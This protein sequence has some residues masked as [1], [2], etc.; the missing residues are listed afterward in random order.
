MASDAAAFHD[1]RPDDVAPA[2]GLDEPLWLQTNL[3]KS[4]LNYGKIGNHGQFVGTWSISTGDSVGGY[5]GHGGPF[6]DKHERFKDALTDAVKMMQ[7]RKNGVQ[8]HKLAMIT[9]LR[10]GCHRSLAALEERAAAA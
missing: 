3:G 8:T 1:A 4:G 2:P 6:W 5:C 9:R 7:C 10:D